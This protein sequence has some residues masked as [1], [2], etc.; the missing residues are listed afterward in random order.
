MA[1]V[2]CIEIKNFKGIGEMSESFDLM[3][4]YI[5]GG[6][7][8]GKTSFLEAI[9]YALTG[10]TPTR[11]EI[12][13]RG[14]DCGFVKIIFDDP[15]RT[16]ICRE[17]Y[18][19]KATKVTVNGRVATAKLA[20]QLIASLLDTEEETL[21]MNTS[22]EVFREMFAGT[23][24]KYLLSFVKESFSPE[25]LF[26]ETDFSEPEKDILTEMLPHTFGLPECDAVY[27]VCYERRAA[28]KTELR[29]YSDADFVAPSATPTRDIE[30]VNADLNAIVA[31][32]ANNK[33]YADVEKRYKA[34]LANYNTRLS[35]IKALEAEIASMVIEEFD[36]L[37]KE[38]LTKKKQDVL[39]RKATAEGTIKTLKS[40]VETFKR[41]LQN[42]NTSVCPIS[43]KLICTTDKTTAKQEFEQAIAD[44]NSAIDS[45]NDI[46]ASSDIE[47][48]DMLA[49]EKEIAN[50]ERSMQKKENLTIS[51]ARA[52]KSLGE[53]PEEPKRPPEVDVSKKAALV[54]EKEAIEKFE[55]YRSAMENYRVKSEQYELYNNLVKQFAPKGA[56]NSTIIN[57]Y[58]DTFN[59]SVKPFAEA[60]GCSVMFIA[61]N[62]LTV[63]VK[64]DEG[65][66]YVKFDELS[67]G[68]QL[69]VTV[70]VQ[71]LCNMLS[72]SSIMLVDDFN[73]LD[74][75]NTARLKELFEGLC[76]EYS[77]LVIA[78][79]NLS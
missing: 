64:P 55:K 12:L 79:T 61:E 53:K 25:K 22:S 48:S 54:A 62:G 28:L 15:D 37:E 66:S 78:G 63:S 38:M 1:N 13:R 76:I 56:V 2:K 69:I 19:E 23:L 44:N 60:V 3:P 52:K 30:A 29:R 16:E 45:Q 20:Q 4:K 72:G 8:Y 41:T 33:L 36:P 68:E 6:N 32:E 75:E 59:D 65:K 11:E 40:N 58:C 43:A 27:N 51:L 26:E 46:I 39:L 70:L 18:A 9:R 74:A 17:F 7:G 67:T 35:E 10:K 24:G 31:A 14:T 47:L 42:L 77:M 21:N 73:E 50:I 34:Q 57:Y 5:G 49:R 71:H